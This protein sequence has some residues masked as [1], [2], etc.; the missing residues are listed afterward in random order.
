[1]LVSLRNLTG[2]QAAHGLWRSGGLF[3]PTF[4]CFGGIRPAKYVRLTWFLACDRGPFVCLRMQDYKSCVHRL[5]F[6][7]PWLISR[8]HTYNIDQ[9]IWLDSLRW[10]VD[11]PKVVAQRHIWEVCTQ[12]SYDPQLRTRLR[13]LYNAQVLSSYVYSFGSYRVDNTQTNRRRWKHPTLFA[14]LYD[15][16]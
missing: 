12:R 16:G 1:M 15:V 6:V 3:T 14:T 7:P 11:F 8:Q 9:L 4:E 5:R 13:F 2:E 10:F